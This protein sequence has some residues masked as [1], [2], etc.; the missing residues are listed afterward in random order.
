[1]KTGVSFCVVHASKINP[2]TFRHLSDCRWMMWS[3]G[4]IS[5]PASTN[6]KVLSMTT[7][8]RITKLLSASP[9]T[10]LK[11]DMLLEGR[12]IS[13]LG[14]DC[15]ALF[16]FLERLLNYVK[17]FLGLSNKCIFLHLFSKN[18]RTQT[19]VKQTLA[20]ANARTHTRGGQSATVETAI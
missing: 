9:D 14:S 8:S 17:K 20:K 4:R 19:P 11:I 2:P 3:C 18:I 10:L 7:E 1:M 13:R 12:R 16:M 6:R 5:R 15:R